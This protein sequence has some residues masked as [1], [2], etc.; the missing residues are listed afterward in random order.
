MTQTV[1]NMKLKNLIQVCKETANYKKLAVVSFILTSNQLDEIGINLGVHKRNKKSEKLFEYMILINRVFEKNLH[2]QIFKDTQI[3]TV[4]MCES[5]FL[6]NKGDTPRQNIKEIF[7]IYFELCKLKVPNLYNDIPNGGIRK[8][9]QLGVYSFLSPGTKRTHRNASAI[10]PLLVQKLKESAHS[11]K[12]ELDAEFD[13]DKFEKLIHLRSVQNSVGNNGKKGIM[14]QGPLRYCISY[15]NSIEGIYKY[16]LYGLIFLTISL[17]L[18]ILIE[19]SYVP[20][21]LGSLSS[22]SLIFFGVTVLLIIIYIK[23]FRKEGI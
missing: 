7:T 5:I 2:I 20:V 23:Q 8:F 10:K 15:Q 22:W 17:G 16:F 4:R 11:L 12:L 1:F 19:T 6:R 21:N 14:V 18:I 9:S 3:D 13:A